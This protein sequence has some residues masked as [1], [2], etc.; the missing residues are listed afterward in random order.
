MRLLRLSSLLSQ[1]S[2]QKTGM[3]LC[4]EAFSSHSTDGTVTRDFPGSR[5]VQNHC[6]LQAI[7][8]VYL[9]Y[10]CLLYVCRQNLQGEAGNCIHSKI[11][12]FITQGFEIWTDLFQLAFLG[13]GWQMA[14]AMGSSHVVCWNQSFSEILWYNTGKHFQK[15]LRFNIFDYELLFGSWAVT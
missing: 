14:W 1:E 6:C 7:Q 12:Q 10:V 15:N 3:L 5:I 13:V 11:P 8:H 4:T 2:T 9:L